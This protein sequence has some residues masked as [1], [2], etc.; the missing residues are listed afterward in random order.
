MNFKQIITT[1]VAAGLLAAAP[2]AAGQIE[3]TVV[4]GGGAS[5]SDGSIFVVGQFATGLVTGS[6]ELDQ[7]VVPCWVEG[8]VC[9]GDVDGD[10]DVDLGDLSALLA[11][12][13]SCAGDA[14]YNPNADFDGDD[15]VGLS[16][17]ST[18]LSVFGT[19]CN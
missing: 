2:L 16:D 7:G 18:L 19:I 10:L 11:A 5:T 17:L 15:C 12:F 3:C 6:D 4:S 14:V 8:V 1:A 9:L 13:G